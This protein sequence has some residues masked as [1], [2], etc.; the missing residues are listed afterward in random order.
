LGQ[1]LGGLN[2]EKIFI[3]SGLNSENIFIL[4]GLNSEKNLYIEWS[5]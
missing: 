2:S 5:L 3:L 4:S 1:K